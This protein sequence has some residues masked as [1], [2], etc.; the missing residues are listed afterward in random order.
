[1]PARVL[2]GGED[3]PE[4]ATIASEGRDLQSRQKVSISILEVD[5]FHRHFKKGLDD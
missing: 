4:G 2:I 3:G 5:R 1:M